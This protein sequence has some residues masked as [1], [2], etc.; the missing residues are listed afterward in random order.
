[1]RNVD[2]IGA[3]LDLH[4][5]AIATLL[6][7]VWNREQVAGDDCTRDVSRPTFLNHMGK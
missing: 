2:G 6:A 5:N 1:V 3:Y 4:G 7:P